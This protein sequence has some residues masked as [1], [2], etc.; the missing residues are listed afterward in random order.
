LKTHIA[1]KV[2]ALWKQNRRTKT[3]NTGWVSANAV[4]CQHRGETSDTRGRGGFITDGAGQI[5][6]HCFNCNFQTG[7]RP[8]YQLGYKFR[9]LLRW[10]GAEET[11]ISALAIEALRIRDLLGVVETPAEENTTKDIEYKVRPLPQGAKSFKELLTFYQLNDFKSAPKGLSD[12]L[13]YVLQRGADLPNYDYYYTEDTA[14]DM[15]QRVVIL[16]EPSTL[17]L[18]NAIIAIT[19]L[20]L[21][22]TLIANFLT[23]G[24]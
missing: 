10:L 24:L 6:Y 1:D 4:C 2:L 11:E 18:K 12:A 21:S 20:I 5:S 17:R 8:G 19:K 9:R 3:S 15:N 22:L 23:G 16:Q 13:M 7:Y 14:Y